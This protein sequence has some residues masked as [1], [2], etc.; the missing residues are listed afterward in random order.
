[1]ISVTSATIVDLVNPNELPIKLNEGDFVVFTLK[2]KDYDYNSTIELDTNLE[3][4]NN[5]PLY[6]FGNLNEQININKYNQL[7]ILKNSDLPKTDLFEVTIS[8]KVP[9]GEIQEKYDDN[10]IAIKFKKANLKYYEVC[11]DGKTDFIET[12]ELQIKRQIDFENTM[13]LIKLDELD[14]LKMDTR[15]L[16]NKGLVIE[17]ENFANQLSEIKLPGNLNLFNMIEIKSNQMLLTVLILS[18]GLSL[19]FGFIFGLYVA[20]NRVSNNN[21]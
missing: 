14:E 9:N 21:I 7:I 19:I 5:E 2:I 20:N 11:T 10:L 8:G 12:F 6:D 16:Y 15:E 1:M 13:N 4:V 3:S 18:S 17:A